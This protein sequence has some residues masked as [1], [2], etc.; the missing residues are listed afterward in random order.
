VVLLLPVLLVL[1]VLALVAAVV[2]LLVSFQRHLRRS[3]SGLAL[4]LLLVVLVVVAVAVVLVVAASSISTKILAKCGNHS[5]TR[6][7]RTLK[8][9]SSEGIS[10]QPLSFMQG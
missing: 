6:M 3:G 9:R 5:R 10:L 7:L 1:S 2:A 8:E 4:A